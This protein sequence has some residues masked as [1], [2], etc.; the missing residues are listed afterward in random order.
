MGP[1]SEYPV[2]LS[3]KVVYHRYFDVYDR[4]YRLPGGREASFDVVG[5]PN[6]EG[7]LFVVV[8]PVV[9]KRGPQNELM[10][11]VV[12]EFAAGSG[13]WHYALPTGCVDKGETPKQAALREMAEEV[14]LQTRRFFL[15]IGMTT[16]RI[17]IEPVPTT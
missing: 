6:L 9:V 5:H 13:T 17:A 15:Q 1:A 3:E 7:W 10:L 2:L 8:C 12:R 4:R 11:A 16:S 14:G